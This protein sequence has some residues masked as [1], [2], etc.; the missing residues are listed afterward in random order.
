VGA[1]TKVRTFVRVPDRPHPIV[2]AIATSISD[3]AA[4]ARLLLRDQVDGARATSVDDDT[5]EIILEL[6]R[7]N[8]EVVK[9]F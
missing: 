2:V 4:S 3:A 8:G 5:G 6:V 7:Q 9:R 1:P